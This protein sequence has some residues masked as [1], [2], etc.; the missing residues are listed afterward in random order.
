M[1]H[2][3]TIKQNIKQVPS[4]LKTRFAPS[5]TGHL[6]LGHVLSAAF[7]WGI[8]AATKSSVIVRIEDHDQ[9]RARQEYIDSIIYDLRWLGFMDLPST[10]GEII[11]QS[12]SS[13]RKF[14][15]IADS[16]AEQ[17]YYCQCSRKQI[18][19][20][21]KEKVW[22]ELVYPNTCRTKQVPPKNSS[23]RLIT[24]DTTILVEDL[25]LGELKHS[26]QS[27]CGDILLQDRHG[28]WSYQFSVTIDD[29]LQNIGLIVRGQDL[30][31][32]TGR[33]V[34]LGKMI[35]RPKPAIFL[36]HPL[37]TDPSGKKLSKR[38]KSSSIADM[39]EKGATPEEVIGKACFDAG[40]VDDLIGIS[41]KELG[42]LFN[43]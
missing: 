36:H 11:L 33:Q 21:M 23:L 26:P 13:F 37:L 38:D 31:A 19:S 40:I 16:L 29:F 32:S 7:V 34:L 41:A 1:S 5:P 4:G 42:N 14:Q 15:E 3:D 6:H 2:I 10:S 43:D 27:Q 28:Y 20:S 12:E 35:G 39:R 25:C 18:L 22:D 17:T 9:G 30:T 8:A 24:P